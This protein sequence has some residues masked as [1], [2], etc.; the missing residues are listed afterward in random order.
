[1]ISFH[2]EISS[3]QKIDFVSV[4]DQYKCPSST[5]PATQPMNPTKRPSRST[6]TPTHSIVI[7]QF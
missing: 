5:V 3:T 4:M 6:K 1:M 7:P 2:K